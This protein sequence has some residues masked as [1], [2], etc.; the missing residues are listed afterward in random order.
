MRQ[1]MITIVTGTPG[2]GKSHETEK[3]LNLYVQPDAQAGRPGRKVL[4]LD[5]NDEYRNYKSVV[6]NVK[7]PNDNG[8]HLQ[9][10]TN[11]EI[12]RIVPYYPSPNGGAVNMDF[13]DK[14][15]ALI[16]IT[17]NYRNGLVLLEDINT[18]LIGMKS[19]KEIS[20]LCAARH[21]G[22]DMIIQ[23]QSLGAIDPRMFQN[24]TYIRMHYQTDDVSRY[25]DRLGE[26]FEPIRIA[27]YIVAT[28]YFKGG[29]SV[30]NFLYFNN[31]TKKISGVTKAQYDQAFQMF[32]EDHK[33]G[34]M[35]LRNQYMYLDDSAL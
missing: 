21:K 2:S 8:K 4:I 35:L 25:K 18:Y 26:N 22:M 24:S 15:K 1:P 7:D 30:Y 19:A 16:D 29:D 14:A 10:L 17:A 13:N 23:V 28:E 31:R 3:Q 32:K 5:T 33:I 34:S 12:R 20:A 9:K 11:I 27:Q 6:Y